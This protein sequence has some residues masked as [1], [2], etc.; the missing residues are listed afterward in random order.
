MADKEPTRLD[1]IN[2]F[3]RAFVHFIGILAIIWVLIIEVSDD[4]LG[5]IP[6]IFFFLALAL[7]MI[8]VSLNK[9]LELHRLTKERDPAEGRRIFFWYS[10]GYAC[11]GYIFVYTMFGYSVFGD[12]NS[13]IENKGI[14]ASET[15][16]Q[17]I[18]AE[19][20]CDSFSRVTTSLVISHIN[21]AR[22][23]LSGSEYQ[24]KNI[25]TPKKLTE[26]Q[27]QK[28]DSMLEKR[29]KIDAKY[30]RLK[31]LAAS[32]GTLTLRERI[33]LRL[34][35]PSRLGEPR[36]ENVSQAIRPIL[37]IYSLALTGPEK[38]VNNEALHQDLIRIGGTGNLSGFFRE[39]CQAQDIFSL[40]VFFDAQGLVRG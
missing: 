36:G 16:L 20:V 39:Y 30:K 38:G 27:K 28:W 35:A 19:H 21:S 9:K 32:N 10:T 37:E 14:L 12:S 3:S 40:T 17:E 25:Y 8:T 1:Y 7:L 22:T 11:L 34:W 24:F 31:K 29:R 26:A 13:D 18:E 23:K 5:Y 6:V 4:G 15:S 2:T 33:F